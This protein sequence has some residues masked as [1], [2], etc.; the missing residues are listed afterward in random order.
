MDENEKIKQSVKN[1][2]FNKKIEHYLHYYKWYMIFGAI[3]LLF[4]TIC[5]FQ[6]ASKK[7]P[8]AVILYAGTESIAPG[9]YEYV[10]D[11]M[12]EIMT[13]D[14]NKDGYKKADITEIIVYDDKISAAIASMTEQQQSYQRF[15]IELS[16]GQSV[17]YLLDESI[18]KGMKD[19]LVPLSDILSV[20]PDCA[21]DEYGIRISDLP[22]YNYTNMKYL[23]RDGILCIRKMR[24]NAVK[25]DSPDYYEN[26]VS[27]FC[28]IVNWTYEEER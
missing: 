6:C 4:A 21:Y 12:S 10:D 7:D 8:D 24:E 15:Q 1:L 28:D 25:N 9:Y 23:P 20:V 16:M 3:V 22:V 11:A 27:F 18:Y 26:N 17:I 14:Y 13:S 19:M 2:S 5:L